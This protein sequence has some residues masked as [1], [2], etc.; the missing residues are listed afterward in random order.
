MLSPQRV[1]MRF[2]ACIVRDFGPL[3]LRV[4]D[5]REAFPSSS[6]LVSTRL[7][8]VIPVDRNKMVDG[9]RTFRMEPGM[10]PTPK[11]VF[12]FV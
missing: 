8:V 12:I 1:E 2:V 5:W 9:V 4:L 7:P 6:S 11:P 3:L 10:P